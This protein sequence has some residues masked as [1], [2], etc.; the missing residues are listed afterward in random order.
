M[1]S[2]VNNECRYELYE[3][4]Y[5]LY[6]FLKHV[7]SDYVYWIMASVEVEGFIIVLDGDFNFPRLLSI[8]RCIFSKECR[9]MFL[10][11]L[12]SLFSCNTNKLY[13]FLDLFVSTYGYVFKVVWVRI[14]WDMDWRMVLLLHDGRVVFQ[15][16]L[17]TTG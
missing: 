1:A 17:I 2:E 9:K 15:I 12:R 8:S 7:K 4:Y 16:S 5:Y 6:E 14:R 13:I 3:L 10:Y 11:L